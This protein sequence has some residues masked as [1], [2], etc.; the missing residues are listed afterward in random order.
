M[1]YADDVIVTGKSK[2]RLAEQVKPAIDAFRAERGLQLSEDKTA[3]TPMKHGFPC[4]GPTVRKHGQVR[5]ITPSKAGVLARRRTVGTLIRPHVSAPRPALVKKL[6]EALRGWGNYHRHVVASAAFSRIE[7]DVQEQLWRM[8]HRRHPKQ[9]RTWLRQQ[10]WSPPG[11]PWVF[12]A[13]GKTK[14]GTRRYPV[15]RLSS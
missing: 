11:Q 12:A 15:M 10:Y 1:R 2:R 3:R 13:T 7:T 4:L 8:R 9:S 5:H 14:K 6:N